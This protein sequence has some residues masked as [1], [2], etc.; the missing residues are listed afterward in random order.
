MTE[1]LPPIRGSESLRRHYEVERE[2]ANRLRAAA[3][4]ERLA[5]YGTLYN[6]LF[7]RVP[8]HPQLTRKQ[9]AAAQQEVVKRQL[10]LL[11][12]FLRPETI[13]L[14]IGA[15]DCALAHAVAAEVHHVYA[16]DVSDQ[17][18][19]C[20]GALPRFTLVITDGVKLDVPV[21]CVNVAYS[22]QLAEHLH[23]DDL[24]EHLRQVNSALASGG[25]YVC[26]TPHRFSGPH[27]ISKYFDSEAKGFHMKE[28]T[29]RELR[30]LFLRTGFAST[31]VWVG[32]KGHH[33]G[34]P[35]AFVRGAEMALQAIPRPH[36]R[37]LAKTFPCRSV[38]DSLTVVGKKLNGASISVIG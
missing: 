22:H 14:E 35:G 26:T 24:V 5:L 12:H 10:R 8:D 36:R 25:V 21:G 9:D 7:E 1:T 27:D 31:E 28:Y 30:D 37:R 4:A 38:F 33:R 17:I 3:P 13:Y 23:P 16:V 19:Q 2:L 11:R 20:G 15:G 34:L 29:Y 6:E 18:T 32:V